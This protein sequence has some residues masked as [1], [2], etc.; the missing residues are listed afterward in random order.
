MTENRLRERGSDMQQRGPGHKS[1]LGPLQWRKSLRTWDVCST[2]WAKWQPRLTVFKV[3]YN[4]AIKN[5]KKTANYILDLRGLKPS[6]VQPQQGPLC[7]SLLSLSCPS[8]PPSRVSQ[9]SQAVFYAPLKLCGCRT[10]TKGNVYPFV[11]HPRHDE[12]C[13]W[14]AVFVQGSLV[15][16]FNLV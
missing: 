1:N 10:Q 5:S 6:L 3:K 13:Q 11:E 7:N 16:G 9:A 4:G 12:S 14:P 2:H 8:C 15:V